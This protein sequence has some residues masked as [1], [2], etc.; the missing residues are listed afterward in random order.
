V[1]RIII[2]LDDIVGAEDL[3]DWTTKF[4]LASDAQVLVVHVIS[5]TTASMIA[6]VKIDCND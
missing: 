6:G 5:P 3:L 1:K 2:G 4:A